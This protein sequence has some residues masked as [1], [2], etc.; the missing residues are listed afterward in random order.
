MDRQVTRKLDN[1]I[2]RYR[3]TLV[4]FAKTCDWKNF[5]NRAATLFDYLE[6]VELF[7]L[8]KK[9]YQLFNIIFAVLA[10]TFLIFTTLSGS[11]SPLLMKYWGQLALSVAAAIFLGVLFF[12]ELR[13]YTSI[14]ATRLKKRKEKFIKTIEDN[15]KTQLG[16]DACIGEK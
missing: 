13:M 15:F 3:K 1:E 2:S 4:Y 7:L 8:K 16:A 9:I 11:V 5:Q 10:V 14:K 6:S 12:L